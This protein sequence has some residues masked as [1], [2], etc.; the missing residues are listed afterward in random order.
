MLNYV[1]KLIRYW[2]C[3]QLFIS[4]YT[5]NKGLIILPLSTNVF[6]KKIVVYIYS[7]ILRAVKCLFSYKQIAKTGWR[8]LVPVA[9][10]LFRRISDRE[11]KG[12]T[13][14]LIFLRT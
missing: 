2:H 7:F 11:K 3:L 10:F 14:K 4:G 6:L 9:L 13:L 5:R 8:N 1:I 12:T